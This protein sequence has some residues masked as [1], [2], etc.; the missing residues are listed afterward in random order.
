MFKALLDKKIRELSAGH[1]YVGFVVLFMLSFL[2]ILAKLSWPSAISGLLLAPLVL[3][4]VFLGFACAV[5]AFG[6]DYVKEAQRFLEYLPVRRSA[7]WL[8]GYLTGVCLLCLSALLLFGTGLLLYRPPA[9]EAVTIA[10][11]AGSA[12]LVPLATLRPPAGIGDTKR[13]T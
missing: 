13:L 1:A 4:G 12:P 3:I 11:P 2:I 9:P 10:Q 8:V 7:I 5:V 6:G